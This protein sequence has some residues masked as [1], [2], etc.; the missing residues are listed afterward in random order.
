M[1]GWK[2]IDAEIAQWSG[3]E[4]GCYRLLVGMQKAP[5]EILRDGLAATPE[6]ELVDNQTAVRHKRALAEGFRRQLALGS[7]TNDDE[8]G[9][10]RLATQLRAQQVIV[11][12]FLRHSLH[13]KLYLLHR[14]D[15]N[16]PVTGFVGS[17]NL[18]MAGLKKQGELNVDVLDH[19]ATKKLAAWFEDRWTDKLCV[20]ISDELADII[21][22]SWAQPDLVPPY[23]VYLKIAYHLFCEARTG[24]AELRI[25]RVFGN[26]LFEFQ[27]AAVKIAAHH[28][29]KRSGV[30][31]GDVVGLGKTLIASAVTK[32]F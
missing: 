3:G 5:E 2:A 22:E 9:L 16:S 20:D 23:H 15:A 30:L 18:S 17:S 13:A 6:P 10:R 11:K 19:D 7:P 28:L 4:G 31:I 25:P 27:T 29:N 14:E 24:L 26:T 32:I 21:D 12:L 1:R 8:Q